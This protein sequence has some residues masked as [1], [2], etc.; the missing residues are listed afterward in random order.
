[1]ERTKRAAARQAKREREVKQEKAILVIAAA[2]LAVM[3]VLK[4]YGMSAE[5]AEEMPLDITKSVLAMAEETAEETA[6]EPEADNKTYMLDEDP[7]RTVTPFNTM[8]ADWSG[9]DVKGFVYYEIPEEYAY[10]GGLLPQ[11][12]QVYTYILCNNLEVDYAT[13]LAMIETESAYKWDAES[14]SGAVGYMQIMPQYHTERVAGSDGLEN[15]YQNIRAGIEYMNELLAKYDGNYEKALTAYRYGQTGAQNK[16][17]CTG[18]TGS[19]YSETV[20][21]AADRIRKQLESAREQ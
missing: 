19:D 4:I 12:V 20:L 6:E 21:K 3:A 17:F 14:S 1:M 18:Q 16:F 7:Y 8:S 5:T 15:P 11:I 2:F 13:I 10:Y 9:E